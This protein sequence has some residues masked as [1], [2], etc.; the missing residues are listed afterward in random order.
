V[1]ISYPLIGAQ[2]CLE[3]EDENKL[4]AFYDKRISHEVSGETLGD[5]FKGYIFKISGGNDKQG[6]PMK[7]GVL[8]AGRVKVLLRSGV[9]CYRPRRDGER[10]RRSVRGCIVSSELSVL[11]LVIVKKGDSDIDGLTTDAAKKERRLGPKRASRIRKLFNL[12]K[13]D[14]VRQAAI[15]RTLL[16]DGKPKLKKDGKTPITKAPRIQRL[17]T[18]ARLQHKR[19]IAADRRRRIEHTRADAAEFNELVQKRFKEAR[20]ARAKIHA[21]RRS[22]SRKVSE[23]SA[24]AAAAKSS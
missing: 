8:T 9:S 1:N 20:E 7:Q 23:K 21:K 13:E 5:E 17:V 6:F 18:P 22:L 2:K 14:D 16:K 12:S 19:Q 4:R 15:R 3:I 24:P 10:K 11:N